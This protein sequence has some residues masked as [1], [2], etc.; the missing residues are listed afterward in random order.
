[1]A[2]SGMN[3]SMLTSFL[4]GT[5]IIFLRR[6]YAI[7]LTSVIVLFYVALASFQPSI[8]RA[9]IM[10]I[11][12]LSAGIAGRQNTS[13]LALFLAA[14]VMIIWD[15]QVLTS[16]SFILSFSATLGIILLDP[17]LKQG[18]FAPA[19]FEDFRTTISAQIATTPILMFF[20]GSYSPVSIIVNFLVLWTIPPLMVLGGLGAFLS[21]VSKT[22]VAPFLYLSFP[23]LSYFQ[24]IVDFF[25]LRFR[26]MELD[27]IPWTIVVGY[28]LILLAGILWIHKRIGGTK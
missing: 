3:V 25:A 7:I 13:L 24:S 28:Y 1:V 22:L 10:A 16:V 26:P 2:A 23:L 18:L 8:V 27:T 6:Q 17:I 21:F 19:L 4:L 11:F 15:P 20:F 5:L 14:F 12:S 9:A